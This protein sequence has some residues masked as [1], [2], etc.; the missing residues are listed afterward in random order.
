MSLTDKFRTQHARLLQMASGLSESLN[1]AS[2]DEDAGEISQRLN[3]LGR[4]LDVHL[5][6]EDRRLY[7]HYLKSGNPRL[8]ALARAFMDET[9]GFE[10]TLKSFLRRWASPHS[11]EADPNEFLRET[12]ALL[13]TLRDRID[14]ENR[15]L[16]PALE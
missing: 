9:S 11:M 10:A 1:P 6:Q 7:P 13:A 3:R 15:T 12:E 14:R 16:Y 8:Q 5:A 2:I 4:K